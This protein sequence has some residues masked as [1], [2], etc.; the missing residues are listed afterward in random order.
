MIQD[1][2]FLLAPM[3]NVT[4]ADKPQP[5]LILCGQVMVQRAGT[6]T[7]R[8]CLNPQSAIYF[9]YSSEAIWITLQQGSQG[10]CGFYRRP[11]IVD[12]RWRTSA[13]AVGMKRVESVS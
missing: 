4:G 11:S 7:S 13:V 10:L 2:Q 12:L 5:L 1:R 8:R 3:S 9:H 6:G